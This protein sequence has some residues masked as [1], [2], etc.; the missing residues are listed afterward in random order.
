MAETATE[1]RVRPADEM[2]I[3]AIVVIDEKIGG[4]YRPEVWE[5]R[6]GYYLRRDPEASVV[7]E[8]DGR[9]VGFMLGEVRS[10]EFGIEEPTGWVEHLGVD[11][12]FRGKAVG[13]QMLDAMLEH[14][15]R[16]GARSVQTLVDEE[17]GE[18]LSFFSAL[19]FQPSTLRPFVRPL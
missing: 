10:G 5:R 17:M 1:V 6:V 19:G 8:A 14:F 13:R 15:R 2:D 11:P 4:H 12:G 9:V 16:R 18:I 3:S 7:A